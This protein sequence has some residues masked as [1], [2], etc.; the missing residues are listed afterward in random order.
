MIGRE[1][2]EGT[3]T[4]IVQPL[5]G[6]ELR[7]L[8]RIRAE[9]RPPAGNRRRP[10]IDIFFHGS[11]HAGKGGR[12]SVSDARTWIAA[13]RALIAEA[14]KVA[15]DMQPPSRPAREAKN[16]AKPRDT[17]KPSTEKEFLG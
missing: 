5:A 3:V 9:V 7:S 2:H 16:T 1:E 10:Q 4:L 8:M 13:F 17:R 15:D 11:A 14:E 6:G 12:M